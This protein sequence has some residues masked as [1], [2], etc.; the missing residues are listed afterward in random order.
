[1]FCSYFHIFLNA[2]RLLFFLTPSRKLKSKIFVSIDVLYTIRTVWS[3]AFWECV[4]LNPFMERKK[5][6]SI[7]YDF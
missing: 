3:V 5:S 6:Y 2:Q 4:S 7:F 1:M